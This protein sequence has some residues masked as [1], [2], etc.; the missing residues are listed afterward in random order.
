[1]KKIII[2]GSITAAEEILK[3]RDELKERGFKVG[4]PEGVKNVELRGRTE[5]SNT[6]KAEDKIKH[7]L[8]RGYF[9]KM[10]DYDI[11]L[12]VNPEKR[13][14]SNYIGGNTFIEMAFVHVLDKQLYVFYDIPDLP[15]TS[16]ILA[17]QPI[18]LKGNLNEIS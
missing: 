15:Y 16:E 2:C 12:V 17:M 8:I 3:I 5:V 6:E 1:M 14:V 9:E 11:T 10:K 7:D 4:I 18:V 13:G